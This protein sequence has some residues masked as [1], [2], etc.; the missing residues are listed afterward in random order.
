MAPLHPKRL[1]A[2]DPRLTKKY[3]KRDFI[4]NR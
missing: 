4:A 2:K 3:I 1:K